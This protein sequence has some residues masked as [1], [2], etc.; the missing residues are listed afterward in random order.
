MNPG[1]L[2]CEASALPLSYIPKLPIDFHHN[3][4]C[5]HVTHTHTH[6]DEPT[7]DQVCFSIVL[8]MPLF[9]VITKVDKAS[10]EQVTETTQSVVDNLLAENGKVPLPVL[11]S[12]DVYTAA[13]IFR[14]GK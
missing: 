12:S 4:S 10:Q 13:H 11:T 9:V 3:C 6:A 2:T 7:R 1:P 8:G 5:L 14:E